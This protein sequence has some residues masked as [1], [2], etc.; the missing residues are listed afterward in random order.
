MAGHV[1][2]GIMSHYIIVYGR[3]RALGSQW[4]LESWA[5]TLRNENA[6]LDLQRVVE[7]GLVNWS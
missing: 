6:G 3:V 4:V 2:T 5:H 1:N 7:S